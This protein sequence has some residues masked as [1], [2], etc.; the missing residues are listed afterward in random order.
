MNLYLVTASESD[1]D[2]FVSAVVYA[3]DEE[4]ACEIVRETCALPLE[5]RTPGAWYGINC[6]AELTAT[7]VERKHG[8]ILGHSMPG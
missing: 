4:D 2:E 7:P 1:Y 8:P 3:N 6:N 5:C